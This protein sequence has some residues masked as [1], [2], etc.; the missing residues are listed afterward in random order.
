[1]LKANGR[2]FRLL[3]LYCGAGGCSVGYYLAGFDVVGVDIVAQPNYPFRFYQ[4]DALDALDDPD[5]LATF[6][7]I[8]ASPPCQ[9]ETPLRHSRPDY[10]WPDMLAPTIDALAQV[11]TPWVIENVSHTEQLPGA[12]I[13]CGASLGLKVKCSDGVVRVVRRHRRF[14]SNV[15]LM[16]P[17]CAC[18]FR[19]VGV[20]GH[21][22]GTR[23]AHGYAGFADEAREAMGI[24][25]M[26]RNE[27]AQ[28]I[29]PAYTQLI[30]EQLLSELV[31]RG[32]DARQAATPERNG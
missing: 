22:G 8:H 30:G 7:A 10:D 28:A 18:T 14:A 1:M 29:P 25:W 15:W 20:Y 6:D 2:R 12:L 31:A 9:S 13:I 5:W 11:D 4:A 21:G 17:P 27:M 32:N 16:A 26:N 3:D 19:I 23:V 24:D